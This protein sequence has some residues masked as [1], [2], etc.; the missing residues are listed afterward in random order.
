MLDL[1]S[2]PSVGVFSAEGLGLGSLSELSFISASGLP[3]EEAVGPGNLALGPLTFV[4]GGIASLETVGHATLKFPAPTAGDR[5]LTVP[6]ENRLVQVTVDGRTV[7]V[8]PDSRF[9]AVPAENRVAVVS[10]ENRFMK[11]TLN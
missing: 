7:Q 9:M 1:L 2:L 11:T 3:T 4:V 5:I 10:K 8:R 6:A